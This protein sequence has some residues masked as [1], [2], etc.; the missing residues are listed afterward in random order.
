MNCGNCLMER[1]EM[2]KLVDGECP[3]CGADYGE[4]AEPK[5]AQPKHTPGPWT[6]RDDGHQWAIIGGPPSYVTGI[7]KQNHDSDGN[8]RLIAAAPDLL[9]VIEAILYAH[10]TGNCGASQGEA[11]LCRAYAEDAREAIAKA[12]GH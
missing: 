1:V 7:D 5:T 2:V 10:D 4:H 12:R 11:R 8:A 9:A 6:V 3:K